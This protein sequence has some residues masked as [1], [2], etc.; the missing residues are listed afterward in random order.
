MTAATSASDE[1]RPEAGGLRRGLVFLAIAGAFVVALAAD[2]GLDRPVPDESFARSAA[3]EPEPLVEVPPAGTLSAAWYCAEG[4]SSPDGRADE[5][6]VVANAGERPVE[7]LVT[8]MAGGDQPPTRERIEVAPRSRGVVRIADLVQLDDPGVVVEVFGG[9]AGVEHVLEG[10]GDVAAAPCARRPSDHWY[11]AGGTTVRDARDVL[12]LFNPF[13]DD[14]V[15]DM[16][17]FTE[18]GVEQPEALQSLVV[19]ARS[20]VSVPVHEHVLRREVAA[21]EITVRAGR[22]VAERSISWDESTGRRGMG[23]MLGATDT[24]PEWLFPE[25]LVDERVAEDIWVLNPGQVDTAVEIQPELD[26]EAVVEPSTVEVP[27]RSATSFRVNDIVDN[28]VGHSLRVTAVG[29]E[30]VVVAQ[31]IVSATGATREGY[32]TVPGLTAPATKWLFPAGS[33]DDTFDEWLVV[34]NSGTEPV[35]FRVSVLAGGVLL[36]PEGLGSLTVEPLERGSFRLGDALKRSDLA[37]VVESDAPLMVV[38]GLFRENSISYSP[39][40]PFAGT[41]MSA[42]GG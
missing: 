25:G 39:G 37:L 26:G 33:A 14:A 1:R 38:R 28:G 29:D 30:D 22:V 42:P 17:F 41:V 8:V 20:R 23:V 15:L 21:A 27:A 10:S 31:E 36:V 18:E 16:T 9:E 2:E 34:T 4:T 32:A 11:F 35:R 24:A 40:I 12:A 3:V 6:V 7:A 13:D 19:P 5:T